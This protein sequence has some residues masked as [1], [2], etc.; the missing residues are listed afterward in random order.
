MYR[1]YTAIKMLWVHESRSPVMAK[2]YCLLPSSPTPSLYNLSSPFS[3]KVPESC[4]GH[5]ANYSTA[6]YSHTWPVVSVCFNCP[7]QTET[8]L[9]RSESYTSL[10]EDRDGFIE[11]FHTMSIY[12][13]NS[14]WVHPWD[15]ELPKLAFLTRL[16]V[17]ITKEL[18][19]DDG[20]WGRQIQFPL[21]V[22]PL[23]GQ[24]CCS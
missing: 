18:W 13:D 6:M 23:A 24:P 22:W 7:L 16:A 9:R 21:R 1:L 3:A 10:F 14:R 5:V 19:T 17:P 12:Q 4:R 15:C 8:I 2:T 11:L 20:V